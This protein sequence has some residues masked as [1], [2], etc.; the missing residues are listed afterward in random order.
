ME[1]LTFEFRY[2]GFEDYYGD[3]I[4]NS[5]KWATITYGGTLLNGNHT[6]T[7]TTEDKPW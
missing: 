5:K 4:I 3:Y 2:E 1:P 7:L 6:L